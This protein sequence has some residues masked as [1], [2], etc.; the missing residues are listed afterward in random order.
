MG[1]VSVKFTVYEGLP[2]GANEEE[3]E[4]FAAFLASV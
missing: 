4:A 1:A 2:H 3:L